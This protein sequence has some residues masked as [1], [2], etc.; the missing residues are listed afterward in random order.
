MLQA[1]DASGSWLAL[2]WRTIN[3]L[4]HE[5]FARAPPAPPPGDFGLLGGGFYRDTHDVDDLR[6]QP[7][8]EG[9]RRGK[10]G[11]SIAW[12]AKDNSL[13]LV[14]I[15][16]TQDLNENAVQIILPAPIAGTKHVA[17]F[18][19]IDT[20][21]ASGPGVGSGATMKDALVVCI[22]TADLNAYRFIFR[23]AAL[24]G[25]M[26]LSGEGSGGS[27][28][29]GAWRE[30]KQALLDTGSL[31]RLSLTRAFSSDRNPV[32]WLAPDKLVVGQADGTLSVVEWPGQWE[33][34]PSTALPVFTVINLTDTTLVGRLFSSLRPANQGDK[35]CLSH[36]VASFSVT[37]ISTRT[38]R[39][40][41][42]QHSIRRPCDD[43]PWTLPW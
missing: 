27:I 16:L 18:D 11:K 3:L 12:R 37:A 15:D 2:D 14:E 36:A 22:L 39:A 40:S 31:H 38:G 26:T 23:P 4:E 41:P 19:N 5:D 7:T 13:W 9:K 28:L 17:L 29:S 20:P 30:G 32:L 6:N 34:V 1:V 42:R 25:A 21:G 43:Q 24:E 8:P 35:V 10:A 33:S